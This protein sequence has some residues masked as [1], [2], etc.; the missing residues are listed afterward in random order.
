MRRGVCQP[1]IL[2]F[3]LAALPRTIAG[4]APT[5]AAFVPPGLEVPAGQ[6]LALVLAARGVQIYE[7][8]PVADQ[9][10]KFEWAFIAP[11]AELFDPEGQKVGRHYA[12]PTWELN[13]GDKVVGRLKAKA[14]APDGKG[15]PWLLLEAAS[16]SGGGIMGSVA[17]I[18]RVDT[19]GGKAPAKG[20]VS[21]AVGHQVRVPYT[22]TYKFYIAKPDSS[23][24]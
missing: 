14:D 1:F 15:V 24:G 18:Q 17:S 3:V 16:S 20:A 8:R 10:G 22:A 5:P 6:V 2:L 19:K 13:D 12:G 21:A 4:P 23:G 9:P 7:C 11:E